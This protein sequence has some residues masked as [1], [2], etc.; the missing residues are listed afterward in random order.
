MFLYAEPALVAI[1]D[2][3]FAAGIRIG[4]PGLKVTYKAFDKGVVIGGFK[5]S[6]VLLFGKNFYLSLPM[7]L[8]IGGEFKVH[9]EFNLFVDME[10][11]P[12]I[13]K[14]SGHATEAYLYVNT[15]FGLS[16]KF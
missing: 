4:A 13:R 12:D 11:G 14:T 8:S 15:V 3:D 5:F 7:I 10:F 1:Y 9:K 2:P 6:P 16:K